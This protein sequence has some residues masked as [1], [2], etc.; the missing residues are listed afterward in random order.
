MQEVPFRDFLKDVPEELH[1]QAKEVYNHLLHYS[2][3]EE[4]RLLGKVLDNW[5]PTKEAFV[6]GILTDPDKPLLI[7]LYDEKPIKHILVENAPMPEKI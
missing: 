6:K 7:N 3:Q 1:G 2:K 5:K 4:Y